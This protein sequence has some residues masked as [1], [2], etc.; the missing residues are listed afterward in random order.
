M[1]KIESLRHAPAQIKTLAKDESNFETLEKIR[2]EEY[3]LEGGK[4]AVYIMG[5]YRHNLEQTG[6]KQAESYK[7]ASRK[8]P[9]KG[10]PTEF[11]EYV[12]NL[13]QD[14]SSELNKLEYQ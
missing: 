5:N 9:V 14:V 2:K 1:E 11:R 8:R 12:D 13:T 7:D 10:A 4:D 6:Q 3:H